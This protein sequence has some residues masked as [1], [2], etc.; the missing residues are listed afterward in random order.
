MAEIHLRTETQTL[1]PDYQK[2]HLDRYDIDAE[3]TATKRI[4]FYRHL[5]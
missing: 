2:I 5:F 4:G 1:E 3:L